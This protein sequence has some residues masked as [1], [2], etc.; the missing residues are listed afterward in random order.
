MKNT[1][2]QAAV[3]RVFPSP[4]RELFREILVAPQT[5]PSWTP[6][7]LVASGVIVNTGSIAGMVGFGSV[8]YGGTLRQD[9]GSVITDT[10]S[11][12]SE[13]TPKDVVSWTIAFQGL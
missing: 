9:N 6:L 5:D 7:F 10:S 4:A 8:V 2:A 11:F 12:S 3:E 13:L 1:V